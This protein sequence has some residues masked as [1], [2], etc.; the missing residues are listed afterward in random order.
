M[1]IIEGM[2]RVRSV[3]EQNR[4]PKQTKHRTVQQYSYRDWFL[5]SFEILKL[6]KNL[7]TI[8]EGEG[9]EF[10]QEKGNAS[11]SANSSTRNWRIAA[12]V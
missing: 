8:A 5:F 6:Q 3:I 1:F 9:I 10:V 12:P 7:L 4:R 11:R 2:D